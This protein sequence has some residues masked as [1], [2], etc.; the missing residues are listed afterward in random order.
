MTDGTFRPQVEKR[1]KSV[2]YNPYD[3]PKAV[4]DRMEEI[5]AGDIE[6]QAALNGYIRIGYFEKHVEDDVHDFG[7]EST[8][9]IAVTVRT[10]TMSALYQV[11]DR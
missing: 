6:S 3:M 8:G 2:R 5:I 1:A 10:L 11:I 4:E 7:D 9:P